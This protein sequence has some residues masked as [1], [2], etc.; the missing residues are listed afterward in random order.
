[1]KKQSLT[2][3]PFLKQQV[4]WNINQ[5]LFSFRSILG[6]SPQKMQ[7]KPITNQKSQKAGSAVLVSDIGIVKRG[8][9][10]K[11]GASSGSGGS[12]TNST[13]DSKNSGIDGGPANGLLLEDSFEKYYNKDLDL[14]EDQ[15]PVVINELN[16]SAMNFISQEQYE[17]ALI[18]LQKAQT[19]LDQIQADKIPCDQFIFLLTL[20]NMA[21]CY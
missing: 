21:M 3:G 15:V 12:S 1:M 17:K 13:G 10:K 6:G 7:A 16:E 18:L 11:E 19:M 20:H 5:I 14:E 8:V 2:L 4:D 9:S